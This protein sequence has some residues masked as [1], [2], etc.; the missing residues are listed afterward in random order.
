MR[1]LP[2]IVPEEVML[3][4][5]QLVAQLVENV[6][7]LRMPGQKCPHTSP[8]FD[9]VRSPEEL[10]EESWAEMQLL[11]GNE[12]AARHARRGP[13]SAENNTKLQALF[14]DEDSG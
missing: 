7:L 6:S 13:L 3:P 10:E 9:L 11:S 5:L 2:G 12:L 4:G 1:S 8:M 14:Q